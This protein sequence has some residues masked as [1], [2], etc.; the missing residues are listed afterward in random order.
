MSEAVTSS[1]QIPHGLHSI[2]P[3]VG[4]DGDVPRQVLPPTF[5]RQ[6]AQG[7]RKLLLNRQSVTDS[8]SGS[9]QAHDVDGIRETLRP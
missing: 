8:G 9:G 5:S 2:P 4:R 3:S 7:T 6:D 1:H